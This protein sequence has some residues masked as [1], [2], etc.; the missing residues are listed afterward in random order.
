[1]GD[2]D[3]RAFPQYSTTVPFRCLARPLRCTKISLCKK[4]TKLFP[5]N[6]CEAD[7]RTEIQPKFYFLKLLEKYTNSRLFIKTCVISFLSN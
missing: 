7:R 4:G 3:N 6:A 2:V 5:L 1:M